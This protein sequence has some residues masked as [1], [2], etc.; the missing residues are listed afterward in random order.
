M[1]HYDGQ[2]DPV[3]LSNITE[4]QALVN[5]HANPSSCQELYGWIIWSSLPYV[6]CILRNT[7]TATELRRA[8]SESMRKC[9]MGV[10]M[11]WIK[12]RLLLWR[13]LSSWICRTTLAPPWSQGALF[14][15]SSWICQP[16]QQTE[17]CL[18]FKFDINLFSWFQYHRNPKSWALSIRSIYRHPKAAWSRS[19]TSYFFSAAICNAPS[20]KN[21]AENH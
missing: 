4:I 9:I 14:L 18:R 5:S 20:D 1:R 2:A 15:R 6:P 10:N 13:V 8:T 12:S 17:G 11:N 3:S 19:V 21:T 7:L 16:L